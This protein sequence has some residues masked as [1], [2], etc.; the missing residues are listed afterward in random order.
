M[1]N[2]KTGYIFL[3]DGLGRVRFAGS[4]QAEN[5]ELKLLIKHVK[6]ITPGLKT[7]KI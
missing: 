5:Y 1:H 3:L 7:P 6:E 2:D 4:G